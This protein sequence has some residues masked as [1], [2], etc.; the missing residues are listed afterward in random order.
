[1]ASAGSVRG[2]G[3]ERFEGAKKFVTGTGE[4]DTGIMACGSATTV[5]GSAATFTPTTVRWK[6]TPTTNSAI[7]VNH[8]QRLTPAV[9]C[10]AKSRS[11]ASAAMVAT[12]PRIVT[13]RRYMSICQPPFSCRRAGRV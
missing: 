11:N 9:S 4:G 12:V 1:M 13:S 10:L 2:S 5:T 6:G 8:R 7:T 3:S